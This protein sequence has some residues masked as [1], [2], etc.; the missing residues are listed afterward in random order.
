M[1][2]FSRGGKL[3]LLATMPAF[4]LECVYMSRSL[5][6]RSLERQVF[7][8]SIQLQGAG[9]VDGSVVQNRLVDESPP[10]KEER[11]RVQ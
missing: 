7:S 5:W 8:H 4:D 2:T 9:S 3:Y 11:D 10:S 1:R 6:C